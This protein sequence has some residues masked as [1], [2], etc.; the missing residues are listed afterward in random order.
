MVSELIQEQRTRTYW[1]DV[2]QRLR[3]HRV[4]LAALLVFG[5]IIFYSAAGP[6]FSSY[7]ISKTDLRSRL[8]APSTEHYFGTDE[9]GR[10]IALRI[11]VGG[12]VSLFV[13]FSVALV[14]LLIG[15][16]IGAASGYFGG[17]LDSVLMRFTGHHVVDPQ[18]A[19]SADTFPLR[20]RFG[21][22]HHPD[23]LSVQLDG[24]GAHCARHYSFN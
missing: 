18:F 9:L 12:R 24:A 20:G 5:L 1:Q 19:S 7:S 15:V 6:L 23:P 4:A 14:S 10:D 2:W 13:G 17:H 11:M 16:L 21:V 8:I 3:R 22:Q